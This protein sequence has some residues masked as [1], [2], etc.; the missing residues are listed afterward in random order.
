MSPPNR[1]EPMLSNLGPRFF[2]SAL[3]FDMAVSYRNSQKNRKLNRSLNAV[4]NLARSQ[5]KELSYLYNVLQTNEVPITEFDII[6][7]KQIQGG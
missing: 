5:E 6:A 3:V 7:L 1:K 4:V 2:V